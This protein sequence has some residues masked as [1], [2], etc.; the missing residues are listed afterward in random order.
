MF[1]I[2]AYLEK[3]KNI[4]Q[5]EKQLKQAIQT[6]IQETLHL[7]LATKDIKIKNG[8]IIFSVSPGI[9]NLLFIKKE[10]ILAALKVKQI[11]NICDLRW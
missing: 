5:G 2:A 11:E 7:D 10:K 8:E 1:N 4:G 6:V 9:K 3:F